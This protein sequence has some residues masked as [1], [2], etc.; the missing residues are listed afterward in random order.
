MVSVNK[1]V[2]TGAGLVSNLIRKSTNRFSAVYENNVPQV[3]G[4][5]QRIEQVIINLLV[6]ACQALSD[7]HQGIEVTTAYDSK[8][9]C[10]VVEIRDEGVGMSSEV[11]QRIRDPF[12]TTKREG[13]GTGLGLAISDKI[14]SDHGGTMVLDSVLGKGTSVKVSFP[15][16]SKLE[17]ELR[18]GNGPIT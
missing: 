13:G 3:K 12:F 6:N 17:N 7:I 15:V 2:K 14:I 16:G 11:L 1:A 4:N 9:D 18:T 5:V 10:A 8:S